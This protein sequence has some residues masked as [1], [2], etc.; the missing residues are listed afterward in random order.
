[1][2]AA[3]AA[4]AARKGLFFKSKFSFYIRNGYTDK[5]LPL[6]VGKKLNDG[7]ETYYALYTWYQG[8]VINCV[9][10]WLSKKT[11]MISERLQS[12]LTF[13]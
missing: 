10:N 11:G 3:A 1:M 7:H 12:Y 13:G 8:T 9:R 4:A 6:F 5:S 2:A